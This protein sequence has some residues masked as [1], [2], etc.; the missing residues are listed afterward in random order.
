MNPPSFR[1]L[2]LA[3]SLLALLFGSQV[4]SASGIMVVTEEL[5]PYNMTVDGKLTGMATEVVQ[6]VLDEVG[7]GA[8]IQS[9][10]WARAYDI[11][12]NSK[13]F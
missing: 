5:P 4:A 8:R 2:T 12:L 11:A 1:H 10:P 3:L 13:M 6:A 9:M 7:E